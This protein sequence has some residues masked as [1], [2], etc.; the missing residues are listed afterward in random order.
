MQNL[1][2]NDVEDANK[3]LLNQNKELQAKQESLR[4]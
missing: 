3:L 2:V 1:N 4:I